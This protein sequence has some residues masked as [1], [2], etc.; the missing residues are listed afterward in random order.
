MED[1]NSVVVKLQLGFF[2]KKRLMRAELDGVFFYK[3]DSPQPLSLKIPFSEV[4]QSINT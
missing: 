2:W 4:M 1:N 3:T